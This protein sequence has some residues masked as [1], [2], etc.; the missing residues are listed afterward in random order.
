[1]SYEGRTDEGFRKIGALF[2]ESL[3]ST[4]GGEEGGERSSAS[5]SNAPVEALAEI[6]TPLP[7]A[8]N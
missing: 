7:P 6:K 8:D 2:R 1:M 4:L 3:E 5:P